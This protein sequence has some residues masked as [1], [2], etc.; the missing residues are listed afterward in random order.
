MARFARSTTQQLGLLLLSAALG[1]CP[2]GSETGGPAL[3]VV[4]LEPRTIAAVVDQPVVL[5]VRYTLEDGTPAEPSEVV[6]LG[7]LGVPTAGANRPAMVST[8]TSLGVGHRQYVVT[9]QLYARMEYGQRARSCATCPFAET[10][11]VVLEPRPP[12]QAVVPLDGP[13]LSLAVGESRRLAGLT[14]G[15]VQSTLNRPQSWATNA[16]VTLTSADPA[17][18]R[19]EAGRLIGVAPGTTVATLTAVKEATA[20]SPAGTVSNIVTVTVVQAPLAPPADGRRPL[21]ALRMDGNEGGARWKQPHPISQLVVDAQNAPVAVGTPY[22]NI[23][24]L[25]INERPALLAQWTGTGFETLPLGRPGE[26]VVSPH[27]AIDARDVRHVVYRNIAEPRWLNRPMEHLTL[28]TLAPGQSAFTLRSLP[29]GS[30]PDALAPADTVIDHTIS[31]STLAIAAREGGGVWA[32]W[33]F[34]ISHNGADGESCEA[35]LRLAEVPPTGAMQVQDVAS[36]R[37]RFFRSCDAAAL[38]ERQEEESRTVVF[39]VTRRPGMTPDLVLEVGRDEERPWSGRYAL[40]GATWKRTDYLSAAELRAQDI[41]FGPF[42]LF[43]PRPVVEGSAPFWVHWGPP[44]L[45]AAFVDPWPDPVVARGE[46]FVVQLGDRSWVGNQHMLLKR[47]DPFAGELF[48]DPTPR[49]FEGSN[50][51]RTFQTPRRQWRVEGADARSGRIHMAITRDL[52]MEHVVVTAPRLAREGSPESEGR[53]IEL[54]TATPQLRVAP[55]GSRWHFANRT[56]LGVRLAR[57]SAADQPWQFAAMPERDV[58]LLPAIAE[59]AGKVWAF[60]QPFTGAGMKLLVSADQGATFTVAGTLTTQ[61]RVRELVIRGGLLFA[62][63]LPTSGGAGELLRIDL[64]DTSLTPRD[65]APALL[66]TTLPDGVHLHD[67]GDGVAMLLRTAARSWRIVRWSDA[68]A[69]IENATFV[70]GT[71]TVPDE[72]DETSVLVEPGGVVT[73]LARSGRPEIRRRDAGSGTL[74]LVGSLG[75]D[76]FGSHASPLRTG[77]GKLAIPLT[78]RTAQRDCWQVALRLSDDDGATWRTGPSLRPHGGCGQGVGSAGVQGG[79][80]TMQVGD[81]ESFRGFQ[82]ADGVGGNRM[83]QLLLRASVP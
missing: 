5:E 61:N 22:G 49:W 31:T 23:S 83:R 18:A 74:R 28:A 19:V 13:T 41:P 69:L 16:E 70:H 56:A 10:G 65:L 42:A 80:V 48:D 26:E 37:R 3:K 17:I 55:S 36:F 20:T 47:R 82:E 58:D 2:Q 78:V 81:N 79:F 39:D 7:T 27:L 40:E 57:S 50:D 43:P 62:L 68:G 44:A 76:A 32:A 77:A 71:G 52:K 63:C 53:S 67:A 38:F 30:A 11:L 51:N 9:P 54:G 29:L 12:T 72:L 60:T 8:F 4:G 45:P 59:H 64:S 15:T 14:H 34:L 25:S 33:L 1:G 75:D 73:G 24:D 46:P 6:E 35:R 21:F 66:P